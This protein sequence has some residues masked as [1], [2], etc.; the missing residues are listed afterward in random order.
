MW[1][2][3]HVGENLTQSYL[4]WHNLLISF[5]DD[6]VCPVMKCLFCIKR[7][8]NSPASL[9][10][11]SQEE[12]QR[13]QYWKWH[14]KW[15]HRLNGKESMHNSLKPKARNQ[16][17]R[18]FNV[19]HQCCHVSRWAAILPRNLFPWSGRW[20]KDNYILH[21]IWGDQTTSYRVIGPYM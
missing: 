17:Q 7:P 6:R 14:M 20:N 11:T 12:N 2:F 18:S 8:T 21:F 1:H 10:Q 19:Q 15:S 13:Q 4:T 5:T 16:K 3:C 9:W